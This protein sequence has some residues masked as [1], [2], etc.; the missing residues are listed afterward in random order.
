MH[1]PFSTKQLEFLFQTRTG[2]DIS[3]R[4][5]GM[6]IEFRENFHL[7][8][9]FLAKT[10]KTMAAYA[11]NRGGYLIF[12]VTDKPHTLKGMTND[13]FQADP[14][15]LSQFLS[16]HFQPA[17]YWDMH[18][19]HMEG[20]SFG[21]I[22]VHE[23]VKKPV[24]ASCSFDGQ[25]REG[26]ILYRYV[27]ESKSIKAAD[28]I[29]LID[30]RVDRERREWQLMLSKM[31]AI[32][33]QNALLLNT[34]TGKIDTDGKTF[35]VDKD[36]LEQIKWVKEG[37]FKEN[38]GAPTLKLI[39]NVQTLSGQPIVATK[40]V[41]RAIT[42]DDII[43]SF[44]SSACTAPHE[45][46]RAIPYTNNVLLPIWFFI[47]T[48]ELTLE[49]A[50]KLIQ[51]CTT[52][53]AICKN[54]IVKR[55]SHDNKQ[56]FRSAK[57]PIIDSIPQF[58]CI[59]FD[60]SVDIWRNDLLKKHHLIGVK[61]AVVHDALSNGTAFDWPHVFW[62]EHADIFLQA[63][64]WLESDFVALKKDM[65]MAILKSIMEIELTGNTGTLFRKALCYID[66][67]LYSGR[68]L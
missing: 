5:E 10:A 3:H 56:K 35:V 8:N 1:S 32:S 34:I 63:I 50:A 20:K 52:A 37:Q 58:D 45:F 24:V 11:N 26:E 27:S 30:S 46:L 66:Y 31:A 42:K 9:E 61:K 39:G 68:E 48:A 12:G 65:L 62:Q 17:M 60:S 14:N 67:C 53:S 57:L 15:K 51:D 25:Y 19:H 23:V 44:L 64:T 49:E 59:D 29:S 28:L 21:L 33:P 16:T 36:L 47:K 41:P 7:S 43:Q 2:T 13:K 18:T 54:E 38:E 6:T 22:Y 55:L 40:T 4:R